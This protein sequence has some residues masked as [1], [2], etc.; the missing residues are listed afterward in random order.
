[1]RMRRPR[2]AG[3]PCPARPRASPRVRV[4]DQSPRGGPEVKGRDLLNTPAPWGGRAPRR[5]GRAGAQSAPAPEHK[6]ERAR[7]EAAVDPRAASCGQRGGERG[8]E[9][10][11]SAP[12]TLSRARSPSRARP[13]RAHH[14][15]G[16]SE[17][18]GRRRPA[19]LRQLQPGQHVRLGGDRGF[20]VRGPRPVA[21]TGGSLGPG[22]GRVGG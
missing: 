9:P 4:F 14:E 22:L 12:G 5:R 16:E 3:K 1:M 11:L 21:G 20:G 8:P 17:R 10:T 18:R 13:P 15:P 19:A 2:S 6:Q 7:D